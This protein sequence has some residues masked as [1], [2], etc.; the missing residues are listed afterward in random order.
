MKHVLIELALLTCLAAPV[1]AQTDYQIGAQD[2]LTITVFGE[3]D[4]S[5]KYT[6]EQDGTFTFPLIGRVTAGNVTLR[7]LEQDLK[8][9]LADGYL[10]NP[11]VTVGIETYRSQR[12]LVLGE[13]RSP[14]EYQLTGDM[15][16]LAA[17]ARAGGPNPT[18]SHEVIIVRS[19]RH[20]AAAAGGAA[21]EAEIIRVDLTEL[22]AGNMALNLPLIDGDTITIPKAQSAFVTGEVKAPGAFAVERGMTVLQLLSLAGGVTERGADGRIRIIGTVNGKKIEI[23]GK[24]SD[25]VLP[26]DTIVVPPKFF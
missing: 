26:G 7:T 18:A 13:V 5:G 10:R 2:V 4:L 20:P 15:T 24:L 21:A 19:P 16:L 3:T 25:A 22:Q 12:I 1:A 8:K 9:K 11:Q 14:A 23:K 6:V 17:L